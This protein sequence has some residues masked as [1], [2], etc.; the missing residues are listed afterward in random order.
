ML[1]I[2]LQRMGKKNR[3]SYRVVLSE[4]KRDLYGNHNEILGNYDPVAN[5]KTVNLKADRIKYWMGQGAQPS[6]TVHNLLV[7]QGIIEGKKVKAWAPKKK[8]SSAEEKKDEPPAEDKK[9]EQAPKA[10]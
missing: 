3:P 6:A 10:E 7:S 9:P 5:P 8:S 2:R 1:A 4:K